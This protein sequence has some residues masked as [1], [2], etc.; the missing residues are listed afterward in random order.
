[1]F[2][3]LSSLS[4]DSQGFLIAYMSSVF[5]KYVYNSGITTVEHFVEHQGSFPFILKDFQVTKLTANSEVAFAKYLCSVWDKQLC[6]NWDAG[7]FLCQ[8]WN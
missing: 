1:M 2:H 8:I 3:S 5:F 4:F 7:G 6:E